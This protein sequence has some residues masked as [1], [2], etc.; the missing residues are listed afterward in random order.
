MLMVSEQQRLKPFSQ[1][2]PTIGL[3]HRTLE[4]TYVRA[5]SDLVSA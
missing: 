5:E 2:E 3:F 4:R 1:G